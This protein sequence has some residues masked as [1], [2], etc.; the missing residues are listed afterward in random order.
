VLVLIG[1]AGAADTSAVIARGTVVQAVTPEDY[2]GRVT[3]LE[4][5]V[6]AGGPHLGSF[7][8]GL[9][10]AATS[11]STAILLGGLGCLAAIGLLAARCR[12]LRDYTVPDPEV[13]RR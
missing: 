1:V 10:A 9:L 2:R 3:A 5:V 12:P 4:H 7:R 8:A 11:G 13:A 6:G